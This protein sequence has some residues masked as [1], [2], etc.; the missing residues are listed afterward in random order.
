MDDKPYMTVEEAEEG[1]AIAELAGPSARAGLIANACREIIRL[2]QIVEEMKKE[3]HKVHQWI[4][5]DGKRECEICHYKPSGIYCGCG[6]PMQEVR[7]GKW[8]CPECE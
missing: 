6:E 5:I 2:N 8:Q 1:L 7:P 3:Q 4:E